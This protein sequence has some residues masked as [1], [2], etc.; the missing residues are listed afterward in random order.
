MRHGHGALMSPHGVILFAMR[1]SDLRLI[2]RGLVLILLFAQAALVSCSRQP[3][4]QHPTL[5]PAGG[6]QGGTQETPVLEV[7]GFFDNEEMTLFLRH[8]TTN[9]SWY[10]QVLVFEGG[11]WVRRGSG[12]DGPDRDGF[13]E[14]RISILWD[15]G[16]VENF[17][18]LGG[19]V[20]VHE[21]MRATRSA[22]AAEDVRRHPH[23]GGE[24]GESDVRK[25]IAE[26]REERPDTPLWAAVRSQ[27]ELDELRAQGHFLDLW[28]WRAHRGNPV[29]FADNGYVLDYRHSSE[30]RSAYSTNFD[31]DAGL[32]LMM[33]DPEQTGKRALRLEKLL[34]REYGQED[35]YFLAE[36][37]AI[38]FDP[39]HDWQEGDALPHRLLREPEG[40]RGAIRAEGA[41]RDGAWRVRLTRSMESPNPLD[42]I[43]FEAGAVYHVAFSVHADSTG[44]IHHLVSHPVTVGF[45][46]EAD[47]VLT[48]HTGEG[49]PSPEDLEWQRLTLFLPS[50]PTPAPEE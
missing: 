19:Y 39:D 8:P 21:G 18:T 34:A 47:I 41:H 50:D 5:D 31:S 42:S 49:T 22:A 12:A 16:L 23:L 24:L 25:F 1:S 14:D 32:P 26:S 45:D 30:G 38:P 44:A 6:E 15:D 20:A 10:H 28:Q 48:R 11:E 27:V 40:S 13:Y 36:D 33:F 9:P 37:F 7:A 17:A 4:E 46:A 3:V 29:G 35:L 2:T 43:A